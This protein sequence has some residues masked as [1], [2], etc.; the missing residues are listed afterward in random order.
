[1]KL[2]ISLVA[3]VIM[4]AFLLG[5]G[6]YNAISPPPTLNPGDSITVFYQERPLS[7]TYSQQVSIPNVN[8]QPDAS[9]SL[10]FT[11]PTDPGAFNYQIQDADTDTTD[12]YQTIPTAGTVTSAVAGPGGT[13]GARVELSPYKARFLR[14][15]VNTQTANNVKGTVKV[16]R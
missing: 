7:A 3:A 16:S 5:G 13:Y 15:Y 11:W 12:A 4:T 14:I 8:T 6:A 1:M 9:I 10:E 2:R